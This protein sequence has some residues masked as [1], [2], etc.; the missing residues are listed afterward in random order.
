MRLGRQGGIVYVLENPAMPGLVKIGKTSQK[1]IKIR[2][3]DLYSTGVPVPFECTYAAKVKDAKEVEKAFHTAFAPNRIN[4]NREFFEIESEQAIALLRLFAI[5]EVTPD[6]QKEADKVDSDSKEGTN[7]LKS[8]KPNLNFHQMGIPVGSMLR[9]TNED[10]TVEVV[11]DRR[12]KY[13]EN[14]YSLTAITKDLLGVDHAIRPVRYWNY[15]GKSLLEI[16]RDTYN[17]PV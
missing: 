13:Q 12:V 4:P 6:V 3:R 15:Q 9:F 14:E 5:E 7:R 17:E 16:Y 11:S 1:S 2:L 8:R 10:V